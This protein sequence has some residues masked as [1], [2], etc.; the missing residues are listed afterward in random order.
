[1]AHRL[2][3]SVM[4]A[5]VVV[6]AATALAT[7]VLHVPLGAV[8]RRAGRTHRRRDDPLRAATPRRPRSAGACGASGVDADPAPG[9]AAGS[10]DRVADARQGSA[11]PLAAAPHVRPGGATARRAGGRPGDGRAARHRADPQRRRSAALGGGGT[12]GRCAG[13]R[14]RALHHSPDDRAGRRR[15]AGAADRAARR[16][17]GQ[18]DAR[19]GHGR[20]LPR[21]PAVLGVREP[22]PPRHLSSTTA[23]ASTPFTS[24]G[25]RAASWC[26]TTASK[27]SMRS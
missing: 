24:S 20:R 14:A 27:T 7:S 5:G 4:L 10:V 12:G 25:R 3:K 11:G 26:A 23:T 2:L 16:P 22:R 9:G 6:M 21:R 1:M 15:H 19:A 18:R 17:A 13:D 8:D